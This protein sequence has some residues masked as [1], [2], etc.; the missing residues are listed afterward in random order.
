MLNLLN[1]LIKVTLLI[2]IFDEKSPGN[3]LNDPFLSIWNSGLMKDERKIRCPLDRSGAGCSSFKILY[4]QC[5]DYT[6]FIQAYIRSVNEKK[7][8]GQ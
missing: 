1:L 2:S 4:S 5:K 7:L 8:K 3:V 6:A